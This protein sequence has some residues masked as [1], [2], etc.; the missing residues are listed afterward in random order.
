MSE[1]LKPI[2]IVVLAFVILGFTAKFKRNENFFKVLFIAIAV[3]LI[4]FLLKE[5][6]EQL[7]INLSIN[8]FISY[9]MI[10]FVPFFVGL[11]QIIKI[12]NE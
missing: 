4:M 8:F 12:E 3:G 10:F 1:I 5:I 9:L 2:F 7:T 6:V 11:Y